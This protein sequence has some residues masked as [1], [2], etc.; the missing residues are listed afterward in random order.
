M[1]IAS[2]SSS[3][4]LLA[5]GSRCRFIDRLT[6]MHD[7]PFCWRWSMNRCGGGTKISR[8]LLLISPSLVLRWAAQQITPFPHNH[9]SVVE[10]WIP[11]TLE[12][13]HIRVRATL[14]CAH[15]QQESVGRQGNQGMSSHERQC[16]REC[17]G[18]RWLAVKTTYMN[19]DLA[20]RWRQERHLD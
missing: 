9:Q 15:D 10:L 19:T 18:C 6:M 5:A 1:I 17:R 20:V 4:H 8:D 16:H 14:R 7:W 13:S 3:S 2:L 11:R 12:R